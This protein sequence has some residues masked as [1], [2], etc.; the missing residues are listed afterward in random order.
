MPRGIEGNEIGTPRPPKLP[1]LSSSQSNKSQKSILGFFQ[2]RSDVGSSP[3]S[4]SPLVVSDHRKDEIATKSSAMNL[5]PAPSSDAP[6]SSPTYGQS[7]YGT[8]KNKENGLLTPDISVAGTGA[9]SM[10][11]VAGVATSSPSRKVKTP[12]HTQNCN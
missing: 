7:A 10:V 11:E 5:T 12:L 8:G 9:N 4:S 3:A 2:K 6:E 1:K